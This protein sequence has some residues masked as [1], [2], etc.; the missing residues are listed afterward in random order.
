LRR[1]IGDP[2]AHGSETGCQMPLFTLRQ[3]TWRYFTFSPMTWV[4]RKLTSGTGRTRGRPHAGSD[5]AVDLFKGDVG[6]GAIGTESFRYAGGQ[7]RCK[8]MLRN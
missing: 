5:E 7:N 2:Y 4:A 1:A 6:L 3:L 8:S